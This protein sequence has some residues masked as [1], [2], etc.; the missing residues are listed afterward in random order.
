MRLYS[1]CSRWRSGD[2]QKSVVFFYFFPGVVLNCAYVFS[3]FPRFFGCFWHFLAFSM[4]SF[5]RSFCHKGPP[6]LTKPIAHGQI[7]PETWFVSGSD[8]S[9]FLAP[10]VV[11]LNI[12]K[13]PKGGGVFLPLKASP[14]AAGQVL[15]GHASRLQDLTKVRA[16]EG[17]A[18]ARLVLSGVC[19]SLRPGPAIWGG[20]LFGFLPGCWGPP[21]GPSQ[22]ASE[23]RSWGPTSPIR[24]GDLCCLPS[25]GEARELNGSKTNPVRVKT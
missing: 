16:S 25:H 12:Q 24:W 23:G 21:V 18:K 2:E 13:S 5:N 9:F 10:Q 1:S 3:L 11:N 4:A 19:W 22:A 17:A 6:E 7:A 8:P 14:P 15:Q 20:S